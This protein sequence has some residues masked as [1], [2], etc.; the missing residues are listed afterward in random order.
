MKEYDV[1]YFCLCIK[2]CLFFSFHYACDIY[3]KI[4][5][6]ML[7]NNKTQKLQSQKNEQRS[8]GAHVRDQCASCPVSLPCHYREDDGIL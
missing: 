6:K 4:S 3:F 8:L 1:C 2:D 7:I 5:V